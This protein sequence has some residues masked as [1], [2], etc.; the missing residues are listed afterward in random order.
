MVRRAMSKKKAKDIAREK[1]AFLHGDPERN[2]AGCI[3]NGIPEETAEAIYTR[4]TTSQTMPS[5][6]PRRQLRGGGLPDRLV[7]VPLYKRVHGGAAD[8]R[9]GQLRQGGGL[10]QRVRDCGIALLPPTSTAPPTRFTVE[11]EGIRF[12]LVAIKNIG[13]G[14]IQAVMEERKKAPFT[15]LYDFCDRMMGSEMNKRAVEN[16]IRSGASTASAPGAA[17]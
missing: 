5:T 8:Q 1:E 9:A 7:Q 13:R 3:A 10:Y 14:F 6:R 4:S 12:G 16:L 15:S 17:S 2:I 11:E